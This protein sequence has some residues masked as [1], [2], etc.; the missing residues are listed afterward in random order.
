MP[1]RKRHPSMTTTPAALARHRAVSDELGETVDGEHVSLPL[2]D[3]HEGFLDAYDNPAL[4]PAIE[5]HIREA[6]ERRRDEVSKARAENGR[7]GGWK[8]LRAWQA[9]QTKE[10]ERGK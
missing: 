6:S 10:A 8:A 3:I 2:G 7:K 4:R 1:T 5:Q 9:R